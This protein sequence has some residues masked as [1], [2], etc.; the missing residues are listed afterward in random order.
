MDFANTNTFLQFTFEIRCSQRSPCQSNED[1]ATW[2]GSCFQKISI[3]SRS[4]RDTTRHGF[5]VFKMRHLEAMTS[6]T[7]SHLSCPLYMNN[8][9]Q[10]FLGII[11]LKKKIRQGS[12]PNSFQWDWTNS[13]LLRFLR[14]IPRSAEESTKSNSPSNHGGESL[15]PSVFGDILEN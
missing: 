3:V 1:F 15:T 6:L 12:F 10:R 2:N 8:Y 11:S 4:L 9:V 13:Y 7:Q 14:C 5:N